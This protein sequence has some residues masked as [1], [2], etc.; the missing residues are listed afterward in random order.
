MTNLFA[1]KSKGWAS[2]ITALL[3]IPVSQ[4]DHLPQHVCLRCMTRFVS[5][6]KASIEMAAFKR[7]AWSGFEHA[8]MPL[9]QTKKTASQ[10]GVS[11][12]NTLAPRLQEDFHFQV[13]KGMLQQQIRNA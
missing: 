8:H 10:M 3:D 4:N 11:P 2:R 6:E 12:E 9:K 7:A 1:N 13:N 5:L